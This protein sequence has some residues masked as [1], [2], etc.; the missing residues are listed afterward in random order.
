MNLA[1]ELRWEFRWKGSGN[2]E[3]RNDYVHYESPNPGWSSSP[4]RLC[5]SVG[6]DVLSNTALL[7]KHVSSLNCVL[8]G[9]G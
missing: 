8:I 3:T 6:K 7:Q 5:A 4:S 2:C 9:G 1:R